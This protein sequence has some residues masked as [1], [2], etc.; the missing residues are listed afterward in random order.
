[1]IDGRRRFQSTVKKMDRGSMIIISQYGLSVYM[2]K[3]IVLIKTKRDSSNFIY[4]YF[5]LLL[6]YEFSCLAFLGTRVFP[7]ASPSKHG[8]MEATATIC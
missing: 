1:M 8:D 3:K 6:S 7:S 2:R 5:I 4:Y